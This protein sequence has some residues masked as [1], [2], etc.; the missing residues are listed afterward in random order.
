M[1]CHWITH[2]P[3]ST[4]PLNNGSLHW[5][6][7][8]RPHPQLGSPTK[9]LWSTVSCR[10]GVGNRSLVDCTTK[11]SKNIK[12]PWKNTHFASWNSQF[13]WLQKKN[14]MEN[15][16]I[17]GSYTQSFVLTSRCSSPISVW[18]WCQSMKSWG[19]SG[20]PMVFQDIPRRF[21][22]TFSVLQNFIQRVYHH[23]YTP[24]PLRT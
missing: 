18:G 13:L 11:V 6:T 9:D 20:G 3:D 10:D 17:V 14:K 2:Q 7:A 8:R 16:S 21:L 19:N 1:F 23:C 15:K 22:P 5:N 24:D 4:R 12:K